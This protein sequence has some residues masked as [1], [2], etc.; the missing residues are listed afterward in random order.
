MVN[1]L[2]QILIFLIFGL[3][4]GEIIARVFVLTSD[5]PQRMIDGSQVQKYIPGQVGYWKGGSHQWQINE[6]GWPGPLPDNYDNLIT[7]I[8]DSFIEN[9]MN[10]DECHQM[11]YL[12]ELFPEHNFMEASRSGVSFIESMEIAKQLDSLNPQYQLIYL[13]DSDFEE[14]IVQLEKLNDI[15]QLDLDKNEIVYGEMKSPGL[16]KLLYSWKFV[17]YLY[18]RFPL[19]LRMNIDKKSNDNEKIDDKDL[20]RMEDLSLYRKLLEYVT[21]NYDIDNKI[22]VFRPGSNEDLIETTKEYGFKTISL[23]DSKDS[24]SWSFDYDHHWNCYGHNQVSLQIAKYLKE[25]K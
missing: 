25:I 5:I 15:T 13:F 24:N 10:P 7:I 6:K 12:K 22:L 21:A 3:I 1:F 8:G 9:F 17:F 14:S 11:A 18:R 23:D 16:K 19:N 20:S 4:I 2:K